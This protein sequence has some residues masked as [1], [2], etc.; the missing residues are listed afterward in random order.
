M[1]LCLCVSVFH[2]RKSWENHDTDAGREAGECGQRIFACV[3]ITASEFGAFDR[4]ACTQSGHHFSASL[5]SA[6]M[7]WQG[8]LA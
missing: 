8:Y 5:L 4:L 1:P 6:S 2:L 7:S 3:N